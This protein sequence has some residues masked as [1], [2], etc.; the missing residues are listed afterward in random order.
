MRVLLGEGVAP[1]KEIFQAAES[2]GG[3]QYYLVEQEGSRFSELE[4][5]QRCLASY[6][7]LRG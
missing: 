6:K 1:W 7:Q 5:A 3:A 4:T 2:V